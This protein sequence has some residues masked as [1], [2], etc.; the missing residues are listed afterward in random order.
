MDIPNL[1][2]CS[3]SNVAYGIAF[4][5]ISI[6]GFY[7]AYTIRRSRIFRFKLLAVYLLPFFMSFSFFSKGCSP[8]DDCRVLVVLVFIVLG[9]ILYFREIQQ[10]M[11]REGFHKAV[12][13]ACMKTVQDAIITTDT[14]GRITYTND[15]MKK[16]FG[17]ER[18]YKVFGKTIR[19]V[20]EEQVRKGHTLELYRICEQQVC[21][22]RKAPCAFYQYGEIDGEFAVF[23]VLHD[24]IYSKEGKRIGMVSII[25]KI[26]PEITEDSNIFKILPCSSVVEAR[27]V[28]RD[29]SRGCV[30]DC[31]IGISFYD[32]EMRG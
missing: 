6:S 30:G 4:L 3:M 19:Q 23:S 9:S 31:Q 15:A 1:Y 25:H 24:G 5:L 13:G 21:G 17:V 22:E 2:G 20:I 27:E 18:G 14:E 12:L 29:K 16:M 32:G 28:L 11:T 8:A 26:D 10:V 7:V